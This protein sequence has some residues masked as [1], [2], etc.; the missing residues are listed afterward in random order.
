MKFIK[1]AGLCLASM[2]LAGMALAGTASA[3]VPLWLLCLEGINPNNTKY[4]DSSCTKVQAGNP[5]SIWESV[6][7][8]TKSDTVRIFTP[9]IRLEDIKGELG[10]PVRVT[11][12]NVSGVGLIE[13]RNLLLV[14][15]AEV[16]SPSTECEA[17]SEGSLKV[18]KTAKLEEVRGAHLP[19]VAEV[20]QETEKK[21]ITR[22]QPSGEGGG[23]PGWKTKCA[24]V[25][26]VC[27]SEGAT[28]LEELH[29]ENVVTAGSGILLVLALFLKKHKAKC[30][31]GGTETGEV[32]G[33]LA[34]LLSTGLG[35]SLAP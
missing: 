6:S 26:D 35:L 1:I 29:G 27:T 16:A 5:N 4:I 11:C 15:K 14:R 10:S 25:E 9:T 32:E 34:I 7:I 3:A 13:G 8:G 21:Y 2:L 19:W 12:S 24:G 31:Q 33:Q 17:V 22:I 28:K 18:C 30:T 20:Y 23:E